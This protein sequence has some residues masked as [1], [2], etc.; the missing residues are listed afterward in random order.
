[1]RFPLLD[2]CARIQGHATQH[3]LVRHFSAEV[4]DWQSLLQWAEL[5]GLTPL[6]NRHLIESDSVYPVWV[7]RSLHL[8]CTHHRHQAEMR[9]KVLHEIL[10]LL[11][12]ND[13]ETLLLK[14]S[15]LAYTLY[16]E[17]GLR[18]MRDIDLLFRLEDAQRA[19]DLMKACGFAQADAVI[20]PERRASASR[21][22]GG[23]IRTA[24]P[25]IPKSISTDCSGPGIVSPSVTAK[26]WRLQTRR[27]C[28]TSTSM[29][30]MLRSPLSRIN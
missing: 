15:A 3:E 17:P 6:L 30:F 29:A 20:P 9:T 5:E 24:R 8:S 18:P 14:G 22:T 28:I 2:V 10:A 13:I 25:T 26:R 21:Y 7:K 27:C 11:R 23:S 1:M 12:S 19:H 16:P 4:E